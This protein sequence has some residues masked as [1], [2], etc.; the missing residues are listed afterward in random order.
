RR[1]QMVV[2]GRAKVASIRSKSIGSLNSQYQPSRVSRKGSSSK[3][4]IF[5]WASSAS[6][7]GSRLAY[8]N[9]ASRSPGSIFIK[10][11]SPFYA[12]D[13]HLLGIADIL[14]HQI[15]QNAQAVRFPFSVFSGIVKGCALNLGS[16]A[17][18]HHFSPH[19]P[20]AASKKEIS[21]QLV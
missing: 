3:T 7:R 9:E 6:T 15:P 14:Y 12:L 16:G 18:P 19:S 5:P 21:Q 20:Q 17:V 13:T 8:G 2:V 4:S 10:E 11:I 1:E